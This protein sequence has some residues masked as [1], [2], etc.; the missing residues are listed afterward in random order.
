MPS[1]LIPLAASRKVQVCWPHPSMPCAT[2]SAVNICL[3]LAEIMHTAMNNRRDRILFLLTRIISSRGLT[4]RPPVYY[5]GQPVVLVSKVESSCRTKH[6]NLWA[7][8]THFRHL[9]SYLNVDVICRRPN[10][11]NWT[12][13]DRIRALEDPSS[14]LG[15]AVRIVVICVHPLNEIR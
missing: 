6:K 12:H 4:S 9:R 3:E 15:R 14:V 11:L 13:G 7:F 8:P 10:N 5:V 2:S 1:F